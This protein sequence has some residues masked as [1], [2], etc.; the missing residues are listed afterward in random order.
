MKSYLFFCQPI[1]I[2]FK[3]LFILQLTPGYSQDNLYFPNPPVKESLH[4]IIYPA[5][6]NPLHVYVRF[7]NYNQ[8]DVIR[9]LIKDK[10]NKILYS[11]H[12]KAKRYNLKF[13]M[14]DLPNGTYIIKVSNRRTTYSQQIDIKT[15]YEQKSKRIT[16]FDHLVKN[17]N[18]NKSSKY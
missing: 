7:D 1:I 11:Q 18:I 16:A 13:N 17:S 3:L 8:R 2:V 10:K 14:E 4:A 5:Y 12:V 15:L 6:E 9:I